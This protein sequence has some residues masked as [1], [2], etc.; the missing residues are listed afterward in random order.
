MLKALMLSVSLLGVTAAYAQ[1]ASQSAAVTA[2]AEVTDPQQ[3]A[4]MAASS[5]MFEIESSRVALERASSEEVK[6]FAQ[7]MIDD[8]GKAGEDMKAAA[9]SDGITPAETLQPAHQA[10]L[11]ELSAAEGEAFDQAY[12]MAQVEAH[13]EAIALFDGFSTNGQESALKTFAAKTLPTLHQHR[14]EIGAIAGQ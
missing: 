7:H 9:Q 6:A 2:A 11:D 10:K 12:V 3:F 8:H 5:N 4:D 14:E 1:T 13:D